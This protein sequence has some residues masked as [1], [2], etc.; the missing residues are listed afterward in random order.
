MSY[1][2]PIKMLAV[3]PLGPQYRIIF[4]LHEQGRHAHLGADTLLSMRV[5]QKILKKSISL[6]Y[7]VLYTNTESIK[8]RDFLSH[9]ADLL[10]LKLACEI[11][12]VSLK[13]NLENTTF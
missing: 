5:P 7:E 1:P 8:S 4:A 11:F 13:L 12:I 10:S 9:K 2:H 6:Y 3:G